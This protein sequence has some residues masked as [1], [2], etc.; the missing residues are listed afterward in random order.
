M[1]I[2]ASMD[3]ADS[4]T[5]AIGELSRRTLLRNAAIVGAGATA[6]G[7]AS[8]SRAGAALATPALATTKI[9]YGAI[10]G[11]YPDW[12]ANAPSPD[13]KNS[14][15]RYFGTV[16][17]IPKDWKAAGCYSDYVT[18][19][20]RPNP[21]DL[22]HNKTVPNNGS[23]FTTLDGQI[24]HL[25][26]TCPDN[27]EL[28]SWHEAQS[29]NPLHYPKYVTAES[30]RAIHAHMH[31]LCSTT[32]NADGGRVKYGCILTGAV[33]SNTN[34]LGKK[35]DWYGA[36]IY[37]S[38]NFDKQDGLLDHDAITG[39]M[40][41]NLEHWRAAAGTRKVNVRV[42]ETNSPH[43]N[44]RKNWMLWLSQWMAANNGDRMITYW[45]TGSLSGL[46]PPSKTVREY[47]R[48]LQHKYGA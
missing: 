16:N 45:G 2:M 27:V 43:D 41:Q 33:A 4:D 47:Y 29:N 22:L 32:R 5:E 15:R 10:H 1:T 20:I 19:S 40:D 9:E 7:A 42:T 8:L 36:D 17:F 31:K 28:A 18:I 30:M 39:R 34:W 24:K 46:W 25:L 3:M 37:D 13:H 11:V 23:G 14:E 44:H 12:V 35:L 6:I 26:S 48:T 38:K 21:D